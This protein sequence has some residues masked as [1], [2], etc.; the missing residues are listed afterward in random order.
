MIQP[1]PAS[2]LVVKAS[3]IGTFIVVAKIQNDVFYHWIH[4]LGSPQEA[5]KF[6]YTFV[7]INKTTKASNVY[8]N[9][10]VSIDETSGAIIENG[11]CYGIPRKLFLKH[12][13]R[14]NGLFDYSVKIRN[15]KEEAKD[16]NVESGVSDNDD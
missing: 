9:Q 2:P 3:G 12:F 15:L 4:F 13:V 8:T 16:D 6:L 11:D 10:M 1:D 7:Y 5:K 14:E